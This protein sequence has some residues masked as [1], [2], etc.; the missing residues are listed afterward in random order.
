MRRS[1]D[2]N[3]LAIL[4]SFLCFAFTYFCQG[5]G[6]NQNATIA[7]IRSFVE[8]GTVEI[9]AY[10]SIA[11][12]VSLHEG[13]VY[14]NKSPTVFF[15]V[16]PVYAGLWQ[17]AGA[18]GVDVTS[19]LY[20]LVATHFI[21]FFAACV[22][23]AGIGVLL[24]LALRLAYPE[25]G[26]RAALGVSLLVCFGTLVFPYATVAFAH[27]FEGFWVIATLYAGLRQIERPDLRGAAAFGLCAGCMMLANPITLL[28]MPAAYEAL[29]RA[30]WR[31]PRA[32]V[33][34][35]CAVLPLVPLFVYGQL[36]FGSPLANNRQ[37]VAPEFLTPGLWMGLFDWPDPSRL[38]VL[39]GSSSRSLYP[40]VLLG[41]LGLAGAC[42]PLRATATRPQTRALQVW[43]RLFLVSVTAV[44]LG[45]MLTFSGWHGGGCYGPRYFLPGTLALAF[46]AT[47]VYLRARPVYVAAALWSCGVL[48]VVTATSIWISPDDP[49]PL[50]GTIWPAFQR[51]EL[52]Q[53]GYPLFTQPPVPFYKYNL[54]HLF[55][56]TGHASLV[57]L[58]AVSAAA[59][60]L[61]WRASGGASARD[62]TR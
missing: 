37:F 49:S 50:L 13:R 48:F 24:V 9:S 51:G 61:L 12:D 55:G 8:Q 36:V 21:T 11:G 17:L 20:Q 44:F 14:S 47:P 7:E 41:Y 57:P 35:A 25:L 40:A 56:L 1:Q 15:F 43:S 53:V 4:F 23:G 5:G 10:R 38:G 26:L 27:V 33:F 45:I 6:W 30:G 52:L 16:A 29:R 59:L 54:G 32:A 34:S 31:W 46:L 19:A 58:A 39:F 62:A 22:W 2:R 18:L 42:C 3:V 28:V 60:G